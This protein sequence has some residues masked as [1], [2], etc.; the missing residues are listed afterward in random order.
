MYKIFGVIVQLY[1]IC[2]LFAVFYSTTVLSSQR[3]VSLLLVN[4][5]TYESATVQVDEATRRAWSDLIKP[6]GEKYYVAGMN[7]KLRDGRAEFT[8]TGV[9]MRFGKA[10]YPLLPSHSR[11]FTGVVF[12]GM[13]NSDI[14][15]LWECQKR[16][17]RTSS[18]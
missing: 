16:E 4:P 17:S 5:A 7:K 18:V 14:E 11:V 10:Q 15:T 8:P 6:F 1:K 2:L 12:A 13:A 3:N 9:D